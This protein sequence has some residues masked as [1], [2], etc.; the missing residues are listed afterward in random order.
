MYSNIKV[1]Q[2]YLV[3]SIK[4]GCASSSLYASSGLKAEVVPTNNQRGRGSGPCRLRGGQI[5]TCALSNNAIDVKRKEKRFDPVVCIQ[6]SKVQ[7]KR[8]VLA[9]VHCEHVLNEIV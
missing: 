7:F 2:N 6:T 8:Y 3:T 1:Y 9:H 5:I 4:V